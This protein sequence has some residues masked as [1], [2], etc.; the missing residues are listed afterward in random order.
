MLSRSA[1]VKLKAILVIDLIIV[2]AAAGAYFYFQGQGL[3]ASA[4]QPAKFTLTDLTIDP[5]EAYAGEAVLI[6]VNVSNIGGLEGNLTLNLLI[7]DVIAETTNI[8]MMEGNSSQVLHFNE[9]ETAEGTYNVRIGDL[10]GTFTI[11]PAPPEASKII[12]SGLLVNPYELWENQSFILTAT[13]KN[14]SA[15]PD[16]L[17]VKVFPALYLASIGQIGVQEVLPAQRSPRWVTMSCR[18]AAASTAPT[19]W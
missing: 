16:N 15:N 19:G 4:A 7:N 3:I 17:T 8:I 13:A 10:N 9:I 14:P 12:L 2:S 18:S 11:K 1:L 6:S 5:L